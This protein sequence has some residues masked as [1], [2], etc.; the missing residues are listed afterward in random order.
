VIWVSETTVK[1]AS[2]PLK[3]TT[4]APLRR[5]P[6]I[7]TVAPTAPLDGLTAVTDADAA[8]TL[9]LAE[10]VAVP[11]GV[12]SVIGP[13]VAP[14]GTCVVIN[15]SETTVNSA[16]APLK[17][18]AVA[19]VKN[20]PPMPTD[21]PTGPLAGLVALI[22][23]ADAAVPDPEDAGD[24][25]TVNEPSLV[26]VAFGVT[27]LIGPLVAAEG[28]FVVIWPSDVTLKSALVPLKST[29]VAPV[30]LLPITCTIVLGA[31][32]EGVKPAIAVAATTAG[33]VPVELAAGCVFAAAEVVVAGASSTGAGAVA[34]AG[35]AVTLAA[36]GFA[37]FGFGAASAN[38]GAEAASTG[39][40]FVSCRIGAAGA[41]FE[42]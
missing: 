8:V 32:L 3:R 22:A 4:V 25:V 5:L 28:T 30:K 37:G 18:T 17:R 33:A 1:S 15:V 21:C 2:V 35:V 26:T 9:K 10:L 40:F 34:E 42:A 11:F 12:T 19:P 6:P 24:A 27:T 41:G 23:G 7:C 39:I 13:V 29:A 38:V 14:S 16:L 31:A 36:C 20:L